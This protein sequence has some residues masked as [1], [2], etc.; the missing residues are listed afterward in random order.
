MR[1]LPW[2]MPRLCACSSDFNNFQTICC[3]VFSQKPCSSASSSERCM[4]SKTLSVRQTA[5]ADRPSYTR[6]TCSESS[7]AS[8]RG[9]TK[10]IGS[11]L[12]M[13]WI[14][15]LSNSG[16]SRHHTLETLMTTCC[17]RRTSSGPPAIEYFREPSRPE[18]TTDILGDADTWTEDILGDAS[19]LLCRRLPAML[20]RRLLAPLPPRALSKREVS[21][22]LDALSAR[23]G[24]RD[25]RA[26]SQMLPKRPWATAPLSSSPDSPM[27]VSSWPRP[28]RN[29]R[30]K[31]SGRPRI[32]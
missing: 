18:F 8:R 31:Y 14:R 6:W 9:N 1:K 13:C 2:T 17:I 11:M 19:T 23:G 25:S 3:T 28:W 20:C 30:S 16:G 21:G 24:A 7:N 26:W 12:I 5:C 29:W 4:S 15:A 32:V 10:G 27:D 22:P